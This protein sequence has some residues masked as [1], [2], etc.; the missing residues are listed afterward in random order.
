MASVSPG[1]HEFTNAHATRYLAIMAASSSRP[2]P[3]P[4]ETAIMPSTMGGRLTHMRCQTGSRSGSAKHSMQV[5][6]GNGGDQ[7][8]RDLQFLVMGDRHAGGGAQG[9][10]APP[11]RHAA[12]L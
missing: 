9:G 7:M 6:C 1:I 4:V 12:A 2:K 8:L 3:G 10:R 5:P 11:V